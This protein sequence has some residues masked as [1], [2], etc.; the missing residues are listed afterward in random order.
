M[1]IDDFLKE[2]P[3]KWRIYYNRPQL[4]RELG[5]A[6]TEKLIKRMEEWIERYEKNEVKWKDR[7]PD[8]KKVLFYNERKDSLR[9]Q[10][11]RE[12]GESETKKRLTALKKWFERL[13][14][15]HLVEPIE[16]NLKNDL[17]FG[18]LIMFKSRNEGRWFKETEASIKDSRK[19]VN[20]YEQL[21]ELAAKVPHVEHPWRRE[22]QQKFLNLIEEWNKETG[23]DSIHKGRVRSLSILNKVKSHFAGRTGQKI[24]E[25]NKKISA[26]LKNRLGERLKG[27]HDRRKEDQ[28][29]FANDKK[30]ALLIVEGAKILDIKLENPNRL[31]TA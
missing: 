21:R 7:D 27:K 24:S 20:F 17:F 18:F 2:F 11:D 31:R 12:L 28:E 3:N 9:S 16:S 10:V 19:Q 29:R 8:V 26:Y 6:S 22:W 13:E 23:V 14:D 15:K 1:T 25:I 5:E 30:A 4:E